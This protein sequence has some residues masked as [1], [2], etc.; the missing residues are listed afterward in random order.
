MISSL[1]GIAEQFGTPCFVYDLDQIRERARAVRDAFGGRFLLSYA[2]K[3]NPNMELLKRM[4]FVVDLLDISSGGELQRAVS[5]GWDSGKLSFTG[6][7]KRE[8][9]LQAAV[10]QRVGEVIVESTREAERLSQIAQ[11]EGGRQ[12]ILIR[13]APLKVP[14][15]FG[16]RMGGK[17]SP[18]GID[19]E[20]ID[21][22]I[23]AIVALPGVE[24]RGFHLYAGTQCLI[25]D[26]VAENIERTADLF[27]RVC[28]THGLRPDKLI[29]GS[30]FGIRYH[31][32]DRPLD[33]AKVA[34]RAN[35]ALDRLRKDERF[36]GTTFV[37]ELGRYLVGEAG[38]YLTRVVAAK[39]S[40]GTEIRM[41]DGGMNHHLGACGHLGSIIRRNY[42]MFKV[43]GS[44]E[45]AALET[46]DLAGPLCTSIDLLA[47]NIPLPVLNVGDVL[48]VHCSGAYG[49][50][51]SPLHFISHA[52]PREILLETVQGVRTIRDISTAWV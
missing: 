8:A 46:Y 12:A 28:Q 1:A 4:R 22:A 51:A 50:T 37:L 15:G 24:L 20:E 18:F 45:G 40:R 3:C 21:L 5:T 32:E 14:A 43:G 10:K 48:G 31:E 2:I 27:Q 17:P 19:E 49:P 6:P 34:A 36:S 52:P 47:H 11:R 7:A 9:E 33:L 29:F 13:I 42:R 38:I 16:S 23:E 39:R 44:A 41:C 35:P 26:S 30:G 25:A